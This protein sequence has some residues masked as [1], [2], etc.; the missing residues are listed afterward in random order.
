MQPRSTKALSISAFATLLAALALSVPVIE[1]AVAAAWQWYKFAGYSNAGYITLSLNTGLAFSGILAAV[2]ALA[3]GIN[4]RAG[5]QLAA[6]G[7]VWSRWAMY[8]AASVAICYWL[9]GMS[10]LNVWR[11]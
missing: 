4:R 5:R 8:V 3:F 2:F 1:R 7:L 6:R 9:L 10:G 11:A